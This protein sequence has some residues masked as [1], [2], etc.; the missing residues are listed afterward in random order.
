MCCMPRLGEVRLG[1]PPSRHIREIGAIACQIL[2]LPVADMEEVMEA[3]D[4]SEE[5]EEANGNGK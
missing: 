4:E 1:T 5:E 2:G 3:D